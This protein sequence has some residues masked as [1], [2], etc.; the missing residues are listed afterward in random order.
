G[1]GHRHDSSLARAGASSH[2]ATPAAPATPAAARISARRV[3]SARGMHLP[4]FGLG[5]R[6]SPLRRG[7][8]LFLTPAARAPIAI[9]AP[10]HG[11]AAFTFTPRLAL[12]AAFPARPFTPRIA[13]PATFPAGTIATISARLTRS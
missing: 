11:V 10:A 4:G 6:R 8:N 13:I 12:A 5:S 7:R 3:H 9:V 1:R 2:A